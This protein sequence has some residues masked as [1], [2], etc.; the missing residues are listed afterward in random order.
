MEDLRGVKSDARDDHRIFVPLVI[1][2]SGKICCK[3]AIVSKSLAGV[4]HRSG[5]VQRC[6][7][8]MYIS[9]YL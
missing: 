7:K 5:D 6:S 9:L 8:C 4:R 1:I 2:L 3:Y